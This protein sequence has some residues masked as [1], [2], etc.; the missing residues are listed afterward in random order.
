VLN[1]VKHIPIWGG[2]EFFSSEGENKGVFSF[3]KG[4]REEKSSSLNRKG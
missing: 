1:L 2:K 3:F 4:K